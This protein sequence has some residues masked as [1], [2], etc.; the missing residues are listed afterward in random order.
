[1]EKEFS[2]TAVLANS[3]ITAGKQLGLSHGELAASPQRHQ[4]PETPPQ[5]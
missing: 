5:H 1:M 3:L 2:P 4:P